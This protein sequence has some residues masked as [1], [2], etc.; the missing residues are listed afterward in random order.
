MGAPTGLLPFLSFLLTLRSGF[1]GEPC[2]GFQHLENGR[3]FFRFKG[4]YVTFTCNPGFRIHGHP[5]SSCVSG[6]WAREPPVCVASGCPS[7]GG[8][9]HGSSDVNEDRSF[10]AFS[11][12]DGYRLYGS[13]LLYCKGKTW[14]N[15]KPVCKESDIMSSFKQKPV[16]LSSSN[17]EKN[18]RPQSNLKDHL[19]SHHNTASKEA[20]LLVGSLPKS[21][22]SERL[23]LKPKMAPLQRKPVKKQWL[24]KTAA[25][26]ELSP[27]VWNLEAT[28]KLTLPQQMVSTASLSTPGSVSISPT[29]T[30]P[31]SP[32]TGTRFAESKIDGQAPK[33]SDAGPTRADALLQNQSEGEDDP[34]STAQGPPETHTGGLLSVD[35]K[36]STQTQ[37]SDGF[38]NTRKPVI[39]STPTPHLSVNVM[40]VTSTSAYAETTVDSQSKYPP[41]LP[42]PYS[43]HSAVMTTDHLSEYLMDRLEGHPNTRQTVLSLGD[44][45]PVLPVAENNTEDVIH[46]DAKELWE[47]PENEG[48]AH[49]AVTRSENQSPVSGAAVPSVAP[50]ASRLTSDLSPCS[51]DPTPISG[52]SPLLTDP[53][54]EGLRSQ[55]G[56]P[57]QTSWGLRPRVEVQTGA[58][59]P[60]P[61]QSEAEAAEGTR[62][63][64]L[65]LASQQTCTHSTSPS[66]N[67][68]I[69]P[70]T[71]ADGPK[72]SMEAPLNFDPKHGH[73]ESHR[74]EQ[75]PV[76]VTPLDSLQRTQTLPTNSSSSQSHAGYSLALSS[77]GDTPSVA[78]SPHL[79]ASTKAR[80]S[81]LP[82]RRGRPVCP[83]PP[84]PA[85]GT[86]YFRTIEKP[87][88]LQYRHYIQY[89]CYPGY[90]L[91]NGDVHSYCQQNGTWSGT[92]PACLEVTPC[93]LNNGGCSQLCGAGP[94]QRALCQCRPGFML[95]EDLR[96]CR[97]I[98]ECV[99]ERHQCQQVC[100][101]TLGSFR[102][103]CRTGFQL[104]TD[105][106]TCMDISECVSSGKPACEWKCVNLSGSHHCVCPRGFRRHTDGRGCI[107]IDECKSSNG[108]CSHSCKNMRG[109]YKCVCP[110][111]HR[112]SPTNRKKCLANNNGAQPS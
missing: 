28:E 107:D 99:E 24:Q 3:T 84:L 73:K 88:Q 108:G 97:D 57:G 89:A 67:A 10:V 21:H 112:M 100:V 92:T 94:Q 51:S 71:K 12:D 109:G 83:Y 30:P 65:R 6:Q 61:V 43:Q 40:S 25:H 68:Q 74:P 93:A 96:T 41:N 90:T 91:A 47:P 33:R 22:L 66:A 106:H 39:L 76:T 5:T 103:S 53:G 23:L 37:I 8:V 60:R 32:A 86:F 81:A 7:P 59:R 102:C 58:T 29:V 19:K 62:A 1:A 14:S 35:S 63:S 87:G 111:S 26:R 20:Y 17:T 78:P 13:S 9:Q 75:D 80:P 56:P 54:A 72:G 48:I 11:C 42:T 45:P 31:V 95:L 55:G 16:I 34:S 2:R 44:Q 101:N 50:A 52:T 64:A 98:N 79:E 69:A 46:E 36:T 38:L 82:I 49:V 15:P 110:V 27:G 18:P 77:S 4:L 104:N 85:H 70:A 105:G